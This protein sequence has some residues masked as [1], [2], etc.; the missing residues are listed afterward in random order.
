MIE[1]GRLHRRGLVLAIVIWMGGCTRSPGVAPA[2]TPA[3]A[4]TSAYIPRDWPLI[5][6][7]DTVAAKHAMVVS[8]HP[9]ASEVG[10]VIMRVATH[11]AHHE[12]RGLPLQEQ[13]LVVRGDPRRHA[14]CRLR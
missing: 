8:V 4:L 2:A 14:P 12:T 13:P 10:A 1:R 5:A 6:E 3:P 7:T 9:L 11:L